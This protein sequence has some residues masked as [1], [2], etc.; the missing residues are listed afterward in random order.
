MKKA[1][2]KATLMIQFYISDIKNWILYD[3]TIQENLGNDE[4]ESPLNP[5]GE[6]DQHS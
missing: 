2:K 3:E 6:H 5:K 1:K 4:F